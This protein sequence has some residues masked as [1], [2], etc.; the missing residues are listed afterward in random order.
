M[1]F[2]Y[3]FKV[4]G[5]ERKRI[6]AIIADE[7]IEDVQYD[8]PPTFAYK[9]TSGWTI[10]RNSIVTSPEIDKENLRKVL[11]ALKNAGATAEGN[12]TVTFTLE[13]HNGNTLRNTVNMI[14]S[15]QNLIQKALGRQTGIIPESLVTAI[16]AVPIDTLEDFATV[17]NEAIDNGEIEGESELEFDLADKTISFSFTNATLDADEV[18]SIITLC[19]KINEQALKQKF[20]STK[21][22]EAVVNE[23]YAF[24]VWMLR[25]GFIGGLY[26][27]ERKV[28]LSRLDG[29][30]AFRTTE[31]KQ[32][33][34][35][36]RKAKQVR[37]DA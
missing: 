30:A 16:N 26:A 33:A 17:V 1:E 2:K 11:D 4:T 13:R 31:A 27:T 8:G 5:L 34:E 18:L 37:A 6:I 20:S 19:Q 22:T 15:K 21:Q 25:L 12:G 36:K 9:T 23:K 29:D 35:E 7:F 14:W 32:A 10:D 24:R 28:L 3:Y